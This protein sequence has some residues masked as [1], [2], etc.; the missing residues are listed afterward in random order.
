MIKVVSVDI[1]EDL[2]VG[3]VRVLGLVLKFFIGFI[4]RLFEIFGYILDMNLYFKILMIFLK[5]VIEDLIVILQFIYG[6]NFFIDIFNILEDEVV[7]KLIEDDDLI[8]DIIILI[9]QSMFYVFYG[10]LCRF[11]LEYLFGGI[12]DKFLDDLVEKIKFVM[13]YN[14]LLEF[15]FGQFM[16]YMFNVIILINEF[17]IIYLY[18]RIRNWLEKL[19]KD[20]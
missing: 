7:N 8:S 19:G 3:G 14:K 15:V 20:E 6:E 9:L 16:R 4:W 1:K 12:F 18:N 10:L 2:Y 17:F 13:K 5:M 11:I